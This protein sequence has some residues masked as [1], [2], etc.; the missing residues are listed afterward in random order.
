M[1]RENKFKVY[2][3]YEIG[4][5][6]HKEMCGPENWFLLSQTGRLMT[7]EPTGE[8]DPNAES[9]YIK[10]I[11]LFFTGRLDKHEKEIFEGD[12]F[13]VTDGDEWVVGQQIAKMD[14][15]TLLAHSDTIGEIIGNI[16]E[17]PELLEQP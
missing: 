1:S 9:K 17:N 12:V 2:C 16:Y 6:I 15:E 5:K 7:H 13:E 14:E 11:P 3:E 10:L 4:G 8:F